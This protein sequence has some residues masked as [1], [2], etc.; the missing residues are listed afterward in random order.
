DRYCYDYGSLRCGGPSPVTVATQL[1]GRR[2]PPLEMPRVLWR[3][4]VDRAPV[5]I[6]ENTNVS[7]LLAQIYPN[8]IDRLQRLRA[9]IDLART[10][11]IEVARGD[12]LD[13]ATFTAEA[14][15]SLSLVI[16]TT[17]LLMY[18]DHESRR[19]LRSSIK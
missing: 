15:R 5:D 8:D 17:A 6:T 10:H 4:G 16:I 18:L 3:L 1:R 19:A 7:W 2:I 13:L 11:L 9:A 14:P 12:A